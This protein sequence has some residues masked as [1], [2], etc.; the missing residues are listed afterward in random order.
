MF[1]GVVIGLDILG[2]IY[3]IKLTEFRS[4]FVVLILFG[5][6]AATVAFLV[7]VLTIVRRQIIII[8][9]YA[10]AT[11]VDLLFID[12]FVRNLGIWG[13]TIMYGVAISIVMI[14]LGIALLIELFNKREVI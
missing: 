13:A 2:L 14:I 10:T 3:G 11:I 5:G 9:A 1:V 12:F 7:E 4:L 6:I 8:L